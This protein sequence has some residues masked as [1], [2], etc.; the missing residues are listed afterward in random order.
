MEIVVVRRSHAKKSRAKRE[1][2]DWVRGS[3]QNVV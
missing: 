3:R 1:R 2:I